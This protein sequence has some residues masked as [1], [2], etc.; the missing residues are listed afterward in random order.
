M[1]RCPI[2]SKQEHEMTGALANGM[3]VD[4]GRQGQPKC[5]H[6]HR[7]QL[8]EMDGNSAYWRLQPC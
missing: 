3:D 2:L 1:E 4:T 5:C 7:F 8:P 6:G